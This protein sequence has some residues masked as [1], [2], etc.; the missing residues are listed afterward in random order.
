[1]EPITL[2]GLLIVMFGMWEEF[3]PAIRTVVN[4][5]RNSKLFAETDSNATVQKPVYVSRMPL[6]LAKAF[7]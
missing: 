1:M 7:H 5:I 4:K 2:Y 3:G 6:C